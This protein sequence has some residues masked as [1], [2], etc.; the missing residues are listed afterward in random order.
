MECL[1]SIK[2]QTFQGFE[3]IIVNDG[4]TDIT[5]EELEKLTLQFSNSPILHTIHQPNQGAPVA[6]NRGF[7]ESRG[8]YVLFCDADIIM[9]P[10][11]LEKMAKALDENSEVSYVY[12]SFKF[13]WK[14]FQL[15]KFDAEKLKQMPYIHTTSLIRREH[16]PGW[17]PTLK[18]LQD[19]DLWLTMLEQ[20]HTGKWIPEVLFTVKTGGTMSSWL[21]SFLTKIGLVHL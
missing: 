3:I 19:W 5:S 10:D 14:K 9:K 8:A 15:W 6:R 11:M 2:N 16:F 17:D 20:G 13:G 7:D 18:R 21:P 1:E 4:S 12:S